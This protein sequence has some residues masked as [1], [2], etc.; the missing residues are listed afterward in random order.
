M[1]AEA[2][3]GLDVH[4]VGVAAGTGPA[5]HELE[6]I[7]AAKAVGVKVSVLPRVLE[8]VGSSASFDFVDGLT[9]LCVPQFG[10]SRPAELAKRCFDVA[11]SLAILLLAGPLMALIA[12]AIKLTSS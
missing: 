7:Q 12:A 6:A 5:E 11:G 4:R 2:V 9:F 10:L 8:V 3:V 1:L